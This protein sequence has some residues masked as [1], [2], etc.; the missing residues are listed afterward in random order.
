MSRKRTILRICEQCGKEFLA[1]QDRITA[2]GARFCGRRCFADSL[3]DRVELTCRSCGEP[4][5]VPNNRALKARTCSKACDLA[6]PA[7][8]DQS[9]GTFRIPLTGMDGSIRAYT[10]VDAD[11]LPIVGQWRWHLSGGYACRNGVIDADGGR[12]QIR[13]HRELLGLR[14]GDRLIA[15]HIDRDRLNNRRSNL[16]VVTRSSNAQNTSAQ[17]GSTS[18]FRGVSWDK[19]FEK[20]AASVKVNG[21]RRHCGYFDDEMKAAEAASSVRRLLLPYSV[22]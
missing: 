2:G 6:V 18:R 17:S 5:A 15:D 22:D 8:V 9:D 4:F 20:W 11:D 21:K 7:P 19:R 3:R 10:L 1:A 12:G 14:H 16:R 13:L